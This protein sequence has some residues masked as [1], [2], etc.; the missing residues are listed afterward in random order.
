MDVKE[1]WDRDRAAFEEPFGTRRAEND[2]VA[3]TRTSADAEPHSR[4]AYE[5][6]YDE[7]YAGRDFADVESGY[8]HSHTGGES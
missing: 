7:Q 8:R 1:D 6:A 2:T 5:A 3:E 4:G